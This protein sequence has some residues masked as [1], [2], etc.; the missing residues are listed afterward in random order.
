MTA[1]ETGRQHRSTT[2]DLS[3]SASQTWGQGR[4]PPPPLLIQTKQSP[5]RRKR[6]VALLPSLS[7]LMQLSLVSDMLH[8]ACFEPG[9]LLRL[10]ALFH[11]CMSS[12]S[13]GPV[14]F[15]AFRST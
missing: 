15:K 2:F 9:S 13:R 6:C 1:A 5:R 11:S 12:P 4:A 14:R 8:R 10:R 7:N 3:N